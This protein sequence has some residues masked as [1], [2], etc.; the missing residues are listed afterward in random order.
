MFAEGAHDVLVVILERETEIADLVV[1]QTPVAEVAA[2]HI[3]GKQRALL[4]EEGALRVRPVQEGCL[5]EAQRPDV[6][7]AL[8]HGAARGAAFPYDPSPDWRQFLTDVSARVEAPP[9]QSGLDGALTEWLAPGT[10]ILGDDAYAHALLA[11][12]GAH[13]ELVPVWSPEVAFLFDATV[14]PSQQRALLHER[15]IDAVLICR[16]A[17]TS[18]CMRKSPFYEGDLPRWKLRGASQEDCRILVPP[19]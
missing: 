7:D 3:A 11:N 10:R 9:P 8:L 2:E 6:E 5:Q 13:F 12:T 15:N 16:S 17:N 18:F 14:G 1:E 19:E 4:F